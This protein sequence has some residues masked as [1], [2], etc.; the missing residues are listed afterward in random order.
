[1]RKDGT[2]RRFREI[3]LSKQF[4]IVLTALMCLLTL[5]CLVLVF[6]RFIGI[7]SFEV[8][9]D[10]GY[11]Q[12]ELIS[13][14]GLRRG[15]LMSAVDTKKAEKK[16]LAECPYLKSVN[17]KKK[18][19]NKICFEVEERVL[20]WYL[21]Q[22]DDLYALD[23]D[24]TV[25]LETYDE[26]SLIDRGL[27]ELVLPEL[28]SAICNDIPRFGHGD[29]HLVE[30]TLTIIDVFRN[31]EVKSRLTYLDLS[32][33]FEIKLT[34]DSTFE[35]NIGDMSDIDTKLITVMSTVD[36]GKEKGYAGGELNMISPTAF[37]FDGYFEAEDD[38]ETVT[39]T[40]QKS[41]SDA[42]E[43]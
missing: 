13:K 19:P 21:R 17:V 5:L 10:T 9:G 16:L 22:G 38:A 28:E 27:T 24:M 40:P 23:Y 4:F 35:V 34:V 36:R 2:G 20:G 8:K 33:R 30:Q 29:D 3:I 41:D 32:N 25:L 18:F 26:Q 37:S 31:H 42:I 12:G 6:L 15:D 14:S 7:G 1:M 11:T 43:E 39:E